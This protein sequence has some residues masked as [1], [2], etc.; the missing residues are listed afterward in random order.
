MTNIEKSNEKV[1]IFGTNQNFNVLMIIVY[2]ITSIEK[3]VKIPI[4]NKIP[5]K[6]NLANQSTDDI[7]SQVCHKKQIDQVNF[8]C[9]LIKIFS[10]TTLWLSFIYKKLNQSS[11]F[12]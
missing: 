12:K 9:M 8:F 3:Q 10:Q 7:V 11:V 1:F 4:K 2:E 5:N 6:L